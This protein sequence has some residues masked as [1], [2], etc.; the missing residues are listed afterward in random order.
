MKV[1]RISIRRVL[2]T[3][4]SVRSAEPEDCLPRISSH[5][6]PRPPLLLSAETTHM[7]GV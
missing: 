2:M 4:V 7:R 6:P 5:H 3:R 1:K